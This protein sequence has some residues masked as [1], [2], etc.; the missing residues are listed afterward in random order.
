[1]TKILITTDFSKESEQAF[2]HALAYAKLH[3]AGE[4]DLY[5]LS[6]LEDL[7]PVSVQFEF[8][9]SYIDN[10]GLHEEIMHQ[11]ESRLLSLME[12]H[13]LSAEAAGIKVHRHI[14][15][16]TRPVSLE[17]TEFAK[18][19]KINLIV[20]STHG[21]SGLGHFVMGS[22]AERVVR[23]TFTPVLVIPSRNAALN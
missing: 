6:V 8:G 20:M 21:R 17:I 16:A 9:L 19:A 12:K 10:Q 23:E 2:A 15:R 14:V 4:A 5:L 22:V 13:F 3:R 11:A 18:A 1:M 7:I